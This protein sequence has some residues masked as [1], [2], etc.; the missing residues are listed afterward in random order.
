MY[1]QQPLML[2]AGQHLACVQF[3]SIKNRIYALFLNM[4]KFIAWKNNYYKVE[5]I[6]A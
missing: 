5:N 1:K 2:T 4:N 3:Y 6:D